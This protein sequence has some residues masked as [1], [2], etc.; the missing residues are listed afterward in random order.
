LN[1]YFALFLIATVASLV[2]TPLI[3]RLCQRF[4]LLDVPLDD[5]R[6]HRRAIPRLGGVALYL[7]CTC[8]LIT[9]AF[10]DNLLTQSIKQHSSELFL[11]LLPATLVFLV[12]VYDD[13]RGANALVKFV[14]LYQFLSSVRFN[15]P[16]LFLTSLRS[17]GWWVSQTLSI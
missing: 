8:A 3:R 15:C 7:S 12:G 9:F 13:L 17:F 5:R 16:Q 1:T 6:V 10:V 2:I 11:V 14:S 4:S